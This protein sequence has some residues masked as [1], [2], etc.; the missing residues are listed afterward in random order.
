LVAG[1]AE[2][3][4]AAT[5]E[6]A[7]AVGRRGGRASLGDAFRPPPEMFRPMRPAGS[8]RD[9]AAFI[10]GWGRPGRT[11]HRVAAHAPRRAGL[12][13]MLGWIAPRCGRS[14]RPGSPSSRPTPCR[15]AGS[16][17][18][19]SPPAAIAR[20]VAGDRRGRSPFAPRG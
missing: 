19:G 14:T 1:G 9:A 6:F 18:S 13:R 4:F 20:A 2:V 12:R 10:D 15:T 8:P 7:A 5:D 17:P 11:W 16:R 3:T